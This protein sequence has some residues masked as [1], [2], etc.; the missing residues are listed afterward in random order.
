M[1]STVK[2]SNEEVSLGVKIDSSLTFKE[3]I[4]SICYKANQ[5]PH[6]ITRVSKYMSLQ[7]GHILMKSFI[8]SQFN[9]CP[10]AWICRSRSLSKKPT[11]PMKGPFIKLIK[12]PSRSAFLV[13]DNLF[14][15]HQK[16][17]KVLAI[18]NF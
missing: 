10:I 11:K 17:L 16:N 9:Y 4:M 6:A 12:T 13:K 15:I 14:T 7:K 8:T 1:G 3:H 2:A 5:K 18:Q